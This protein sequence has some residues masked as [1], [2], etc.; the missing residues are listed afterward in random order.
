MVLEHL[1]PE[2]WLEKK[3]RYAF[4]LAIIYSTVSI[5]VARMLFSANSGL[6]AIVFVSILLIPYLD[7]LF[8]KEEIK[9]LHEQGGFKIKTFL[10]DNWPAIKVYTAL[11]FGIYFTFM[12]FSFLLPVWGFDTSSVFREQ[13]AIEANMT[14]GATSFYTELFEKIFVNNWWVLLACFLLAILVGDGVIFFIAWNASTWG[15][16]FGARALN[17][18]LSG[19]FGDPITNLATIVTITFPHVLLEGGAYIL[20]A[21]AGSVISET[22]VTR[23][24]DMPNFLTYF[25]IAIMSFILF[26]IVISTFGFSTMMSTILYILAACFLLRIIGQSFTDPDHKKVFA[27][28]V[29]LFYVAIGL[30]F[31]GVLVETYVLSNSNLLAMVYQA[32]LS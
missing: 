4:L 19:G 5:I 29:W 10:Q 22:V 6:V 23:S 25:F 14:G 1:F 7:K 12:I 2:D 24:K 27:Y 30:F 32:A 13:L 15:A 21:I 17:A 3:V 20:A 8:Y 11:F 9:E 16:I 26:V 28:N 18:S 31:I